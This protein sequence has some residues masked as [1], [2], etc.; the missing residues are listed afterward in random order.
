MAVPDRF[1]V[2]VVGLSF[3]PGYPDN[4][5]A[6]AEAFA[7]LPP[8]A[9]GEATLV[10]DVDNAHDANAVAILAAGAHVGYLPAALAAKVAPE[11]DAGTRFLVTG[12]EVLIHPEHP[13]RPGL[14]VQVQRIHTQGP[15]R[16]QG[17]ATP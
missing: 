6:L 10:R 12:A 17:G 16:P 4:V 15:E 11:I 8:G 3:R 13:E 2:K 7:A 1:E 5:L 9:A 14:L